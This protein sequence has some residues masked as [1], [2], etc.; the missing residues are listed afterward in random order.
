MSWLK[1]EGL[2]RC[3]N[4]GGRGRASVQDDSVT[5]TDVYVGEHFVKVKYFQADE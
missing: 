2:Q 5:C 1:E 3:I 4:T